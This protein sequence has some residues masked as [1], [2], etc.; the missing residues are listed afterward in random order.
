M[1]AVRLS[2]IFSLLASHFSLLS[3][4]DR[5]TRLTA[6]LG[7]VS[8]AGNT[9]VT[10]FNFGEQ[11]THAAGPWRFQ[12]AFTALYGRTDGEKS[13]E[14]IRLGGRADYGLSARV[15]VYGLVG[16][17]R[18]EFAG[19]SR[20]FEEGVGLA[21]NLLE[22]ERT[23]LTA[24]GGVGATQQRSTAGERST[25]LSGRAASRFTHRFTEKATLQQG[26]EFLPSF[27]VAEV[28]RILSETSLVAPLFGIIAI[29][30]SY[31]VRFDNLP[32]PGF[33]KSD[34]VLTTGIQL[35]W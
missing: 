30:V 8:A 5:P 1:L 9:S 26:H 14:Q 21:V 3:A 29:K 18:N 7:F 20:R 4:Q 32:E 16:W 33:R 15:A 19:I 12:Q 28:Y 27:D 13:A 2:L 25:F 35:S 24:E 11:V 10:S 17:D 6:D 31:V 23:E 34:R 22:G